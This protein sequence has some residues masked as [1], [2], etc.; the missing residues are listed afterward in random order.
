MLIVL[1]VPYLVG[2]SGIEPLFIYHESLILSF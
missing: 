1:V 2:N